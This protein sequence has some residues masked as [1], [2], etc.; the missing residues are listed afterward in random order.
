MPARYAASRFLAPARS[1]PVGLADVALAVSPALVFVPAA[2]TRYVD[3]DEGSYVLVAKLAFDGRIPYHDFLHTQMPLLP[4]VVGAWSTIFGESWYA[5]RLLFAVLAVALGVLLYMHLARRHGRVLAAAGVAAYALSD[6]AVGSFTPVKTQGLSAFL[7]F[8]AFVA[9]D[10]AAPMSHARWLAGFFLLGLAIDVR[11]LFVAA[12]PAF[13]WALLRVTSAGERG[14]ALG[15]A[16][17]GLALGLAPSIALFAVDPDRFVFGNLGAHAT[18]TEAGLVGDLRQKVVL[19][20]SML[21]VSQYLLAVLAAALAVVAL[22]MLGR[23]LPLSVLVAGPIVL[24]SF[25]PTPAYDSYFSVAVPFAV[26]AAVELAAAVRDRVQLV[27]DAPL[28]RVLASLGGG[29]LAAYFVLGVIGLYGWLRGSGQP[30][31]FRISQIER[32]SA[33]VDENTRPGDA[34]VSS[35]PGYLFGTHAVPLA[36]LE[37]DFAPHD[38]ARLSPEEAVRY[39]L[40]TADG[41]EA[42]IRSRETRLVVARPW[43]G[44]GPL[45]DYRGAAERAGYRVAADVGGARIYVLPS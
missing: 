39:H 12:I 17:A 30:G 35:W 6:L 16:A 22:P 29:V 7:L 25:L 20:E 42:A 24:V 45:P 38:A 41:V 36:G 11:L 27:G 28:A 15:A 33:I 1:P 9:I 4:Y 3:G 14:R 32:V 2:L 40:L 31:D 34:V 10:R 19:A 13:V 26:V 21:G 5:A 18:R 37:S 23:G 43:H 8:A 44:Q